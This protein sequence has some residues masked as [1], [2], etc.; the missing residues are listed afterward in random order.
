ML[1]FM[2][3]CTKDSE[4]VSFGNDSFCKSGRRAP[5]IKE[6]D[7]GDWEKQSP[8]GWKEHPDSD[9]KIHN[10]AGGGVV[11]ADF[12]GDGREDVYLAKVSTDELFLNQGERQFTLA[13]DWIPQRPQTTL[14][15]PT[16]SVGG[17]AADYDGDGDQDLFLLTV[18]GP[19]VLLRNEGDHFTDQTLA[20]GLSLNEQD[21][22]AAVWADY[23]LDGD[24]DLFVGAHL[25][26]LFSFAASDDDYA[27]PEPG[28]N[29]LY[30]NDG[31]FFTEVDL[32]IESEHEFTLGAAWLQYEP[33]ELP[34]LYVVNDFGQ[35]NTPN[36]LYRQTQEG[37]EPES[38]R[39]GAELGMFGMGLSVGDLNDDLLPDMWISDEKSA[40]LL[41]SMGDREWYEASS[42]LGLDFVL[43]SQRFGWGGNLVDFEND[44]DL[45][46]FVGYGPLPGYHLDPEDDPPEQHDSFFLNSKG[47]FRWKTGDWKL[48]DGNVSRGAIFAD[49]DHDG[50]LD[51]IRPSLVGPAEIM[52]GDCMGGN[53]LSIALR[54]TQSKNLNG[55][56]ARVVVEGGE[57]RWTRWV[58]SGESFASSAPSVAHFG[59]GSYDGSVTVTVDWV[60]GHRTQKKISVL[61]QRKI[62]SR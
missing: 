1:I 48:D 30:R 54:D 17:A 52:W 60:D 16:A 29:H 26:A 53:W 56:G 8:D 45:D 25:E 38:S 62:I 12:N 27:Y 14:E 4:Q 9:W 44:G 43:S 18:H 33:G 10:F 39:S 19:D 2:F 36:R 11:V 35:Y 15:L 57:E 61:N 50:L 41:L 42:S 59:L 58:V 34:D 55:I 7:Q 28:P 37:F 13:S 24:L 20:V 23:D 31:D 32:Y 22:G 51:L 49:L 40:K 47:Q 21:S 46:A 6:E 3:A 5:W